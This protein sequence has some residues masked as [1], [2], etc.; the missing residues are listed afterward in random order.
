MS[1]QM[2]GA[3]GAL[4]ATRI[5][6]HL[7]TRW[8]ARELRVLDETDSTNRVVAELAAE[9][10]AAN[11]A[12]VIAEAQRA[13]RGRHGRAFFSPAGCNLYSSTLLR[14]QGSAAIAP[15]AVLAAGL[16]VAETV[17]RELGARERVSIKWPNDVQIDGLK[18]CGILMESLPG[19]AVLG[20]GVNLNLHREHLPEEFQKRATT[21]LAACGRQID[22]ARFAAR[23]YGILENRLDR[24]VQ[25]HDNGFEAL[26]V[27][28][29]GFLQMRGQRVRVND[30]ENRPQAE[31]VVLGIGGDGS[32][33]LRD[34]AG[35]EQRVLAGDVTL[36]K[37]G[38]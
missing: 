16:A 6:A 36:A 17:A 8:L 34:D 33:R 11:G 7:E 1:L 37:E 13:G 38:S 32:L 9:G 4:S 12:T 20:I 29:E 26:R 31:G 21:L 15:T 14:P 3:D 19:G 2:P 23:L 10:A 28:L 35:Q 30:L 24:L 22:R 18:C 27:Q 5:H 25:E